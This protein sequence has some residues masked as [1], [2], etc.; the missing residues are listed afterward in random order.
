M[1]AYH[2]DHDGPL[3]PT[4]QFLAQP[5]ILARLDDWRP[6]DG[7]RAVIA[8][9]L[10]RPIGAAWYCFG[11]EANHAYGYIDTKTPEIGIGVLRDYRRRGVGRMLI[12]ALID[13]ARHEGVGA[14]S[15]SVD[16]AN[17]ALQLYQSVGFVRVRT[18][19]SSLTMRLGL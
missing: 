17:H 15:L 1:E 13:R 9:L 8:E 3:P 4:D 18:Y 11:T 14:L 2:W 7:D 10:G 16:P 12:N 6:D 5:H 19:E